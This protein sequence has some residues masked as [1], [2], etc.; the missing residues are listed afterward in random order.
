MSET[1]SLPTAI[2]LF[3][4]VGGMALGFRQAGFDVPLGVDNSTRA[5]QCHDANFPDSRTLTADVSDLSGTA[6]RAALGWRKNDR[7][8]VVFGGPPCQGFSIG[9]VRDPLDGRNNLILQF[10]RLVVEL[11][12]KYFVME[13]VA[14]I[15]EGRFA[16]QLDAFSQAVQAGG[17]SLTAPFQVLNAADFGVPQRRKRVFF[18]GT[19]TGRPAAQYPT[20]TLPRTS[21]WNAIRDLAEPFERCR[22]E[23]VDVF[24]GRLGPAS[25][26]ALIMRGE[27]R[28]P[29]DRWPLEPKRPSPL[30][31]FAA[32]A[33]SAA[34]EKRFSSLA[35]GEADTVS[36]FIRLQKD[37]VSSTLRAGTGKDR[38]R[39]M[40]P[41]PIHPVSPRCV[42]LREAARLHSYPDWFKFDDTKWHGFMQI[43]NSVPPRL[44]RSVAS[45][46]R[47][48]LLSSQRSEP[49]R[50]QNSRVA[51]ME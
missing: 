22:R 32:T 17:Y 2:D 25:H 12:P 16:P 36:R 45:S 4:G 41:R 21:V 34:T 1:S 11:R 35:P 8:D 9:G 49:P 10:A 46:V 30:T 51:V 37:G 38:G 14:G 42:C 19:E 28:D 6:I 13:N 40:A 26:Y 3:S 24:D 27:I 7:P 44:A 47:E 43:G 33:H 48:A 5:L 20:V 50:R 15:L 39:Y 18:L 31:G 23:G 29:L